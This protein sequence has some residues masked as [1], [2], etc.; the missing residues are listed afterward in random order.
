MARVVIGIRVDFM[1]SFKWK[2]FSI[3]SIDPSKRLI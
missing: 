3:R 1:N 2:D